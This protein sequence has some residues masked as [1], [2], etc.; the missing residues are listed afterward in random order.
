MTRNAFEDYYIN[1]AGNGIPVFVGGRS[2]RGNGLGGILSG[3]A[4]MVVPVLKRG[5]KRLLKESLRTG[6]GILGDVEA[7]GNLKTSAKSRL[8][9]GGTRLLDQVVS[10]VTQPETTAKQKRN[11]KRKQTKRA[12]QSKNNPK[13]R[14]VITQN[15]DIFSETRMAHPHSCE[16][17]DTGLDLF[18]VPLIQTSVEDGSWIEYQPLATITDSGPIEFI[19]KEDVE[20]YLDLTNSYIHAQVKVVKADNSSLNRKTM[21]S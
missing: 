12:P 14:R 3:L 1:Q 7:G 20:T 16:C 18:T 17:T 11:K 13:K 2:Q 6:V 19:V 10:G 5:G 21:I 8:K 9:Q 15:K 4:R